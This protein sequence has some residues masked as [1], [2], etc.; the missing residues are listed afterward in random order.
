MS[1]GK[2]AAI[3]VTCGVLF[4]KPLHAMRQDKPMMRFVRAFIVGLLFR[5]GPATVERLIIA[6]V[7]D[8]VDR[9]PRWTWSHIS[10]KTFKTSLASIA[11]RPSLTNG[12]SAPAIILVL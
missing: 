1:K 4:A 9:R 2:F 6:V 10:E 12:Y 3:C 8:A 5:C 11:E 7:V